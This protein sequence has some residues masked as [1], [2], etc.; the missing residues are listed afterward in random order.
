MAGPAI[1]AWQ[2][3]HALSREHEVVLATTQHCELSH[4]DFEIRRVDNRGMEELEAWC[5]VF[6]FQG[7]LMHQHPCLQR[8]SKVIV[9][10]IYDPFHLEQLEQARDL[11]E[12]RRGDV[13]R[14]S[15]QVLNQQLR[16]GDL[17][18]CASPK[19]RDFWLGQLAAVGRINPRTYD[20]A[21]NL[22]SLITVV[23]F[24]VGDAPPVA[25]GP[26]M[27]G[28]IPGIGPD[29]RIVIWGGGI[30]NWFDPLTLIRAIGKVSA[31]RSD[32]R[33][34]FMGV[35]HPNPDVPEMRM[36][37]EARRL[38]DQLGLTGRSVFFNEAWVPYDQRQNFLLEA[39][40]GISTHF[41]HI[42]TEFSFRTRILD[43]LW[44]SLPIICTE[45]DSLAE[46]VERR[47]LGL[48][49]PPEDADA[50]AAAISR[51]LDEDDL[52][53]GALA[54]LP[55]VAQEMRWVHSLSPL[56]EFCRSPRRAPDLL[57]GDL[58]ELSD[59]AS[60]AVPSRLRQDLVHIRH[61]FATGGVRKVLS[62]ARGRVR[63]R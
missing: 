14:S 45:G 7:F 36:A 44:A 2:I 32:V 61:A 20:D 53:Q 13:V 57:T 29:D 18:L 10:D 11:G 28:V 51:L 17:F 60:P 1:R 3:A 56:V 43:Y 27:R 4:P 5:D 22:G 54:A 39:D 30:Y 47:G 42:E 31:E 21:E 12:Q 23:P 9:C 48:T 40:I 24:G 55:A 8:S 63:R 58:A 19:Q 25:S 16:R 52:R 34:V 49:V 15:T 6:I 62:K 38:S 35:K 33:L 26:A 37:V 50:L 59:L 46:L 41:D